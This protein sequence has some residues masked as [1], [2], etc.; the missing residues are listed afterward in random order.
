MASISRIWVHTLFYFEQISGWEIKIAVNFQAC[1]PLYGRNFNNSTFLGTNVLPFH[2]LSAFDDGFL[3][4]LIWQSSDL[5]SKW[6][7]ALGSSLSYCHLRTSN[8]TITT[9][10]SGSQRIVHFYQNLPP[11]IP[12]FLYFFNVLA[13]L[14]SDDTWF[15]Q[16]PLLIVSSI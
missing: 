2:S 9:A 14:S 10:P 13:I 1:T 8:S 5:L 12:Y 4:W 15:L 11:Q 7:L 16:V 3:W 6:T